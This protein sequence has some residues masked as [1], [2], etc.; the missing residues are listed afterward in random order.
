MTVDGTSAHL[1]PYPAGQ[2]VEADVVDHG[3]RA[4]VAVLATPRAVWSLE[5]VTAGSSRARAQFRGML[6]TLAVS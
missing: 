1:Q 2:A 4:H 6:E 3:H 5:L